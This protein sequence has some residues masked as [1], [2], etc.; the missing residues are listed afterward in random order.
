M[1]RAFD[2]LQ[3]RFVI[4]RGPTRWWSRENFQYIM[5]TCIILYNMIVEDERDEYI[6]EIFDLNDIPTDPMRA[7][8]YK[9]SPPN[10]HDTTMELYPQ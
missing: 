8:I 3:A 1:E 10:E 4:I 5:M 6:H 2:I 7:E 9:R